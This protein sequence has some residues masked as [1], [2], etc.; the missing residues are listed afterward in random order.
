MIQRILKMLGALGTST[1]LT[2]VTQLLLPPAFLHY[3]GVTL[4]GEWIVLAGTLSYLG[5]LNF[6]ITTYA[7]NELTMLHKRAEIEQYRKLQATTLALLLSMVGIGL[8]ITSTVFLLPLGKLL[9]LSAIAPGDVTVTA[10]FLGLQ[11]L[12]NIL[13]GYYNSL[14]MVVEQTHRG[15]SWGIARSFGTTIAC[16]I[17]AI[18]RVDF[19]FLALGQFIAVLVITLLSI[20]DLKRC[21]GDLPLGLEGASWN[22]ALRTLKPSGMF[23]MIFA[24]QLLTYQVPVNILQWILGPS[25]VVLFNTSRTVLSSAR[26]VLS[27]ITNAIAPEITFSYAN[28]DMKKLLSIFHH[29]EKIVFAGIPVTNLGA[30][31]LAPIIVH[32]WLHR[33]ALFDPYTYGLMALI[34]A[35]SSV[36]DHKQFFQ[37][38]TNM[39][40]RLSVIVF[41]T[42][43]VMI[44]LSIP[45]IRWFGL[46]GFLGVWLAS[47][48]TQMA[49]IYRENRKLFGNDV[50]ITFTPVIKLVVVML[51]S[52]PLCM[53]LVYFAQMRSLWMVGAAAAAGEVVLILES[54]FVFGLKDVWLELEQTIRRSRGLLEAPPAG[55]GPF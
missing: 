28:R 37:F 11:T 6:G 43:L 10:F 25:V 15:L 55:P 5:T 35:A 20:Y 7:S 53:G 18:F 17:L 36:R 48:V 40:R 33:P 19:R 31:L 9:H 27:P 54:Y 26:Q 39:H 45:L 42:N 30:Y 50:S 2:L 4:Y 38:S 1:G 24:Q 16:F 12:V 14:F 23:A 44:G 22:E 47:E 21:L 51:V 41:F 13:A 52:L 29:S 46:Y 49:F 3:Y 32:F 34:S 8:A